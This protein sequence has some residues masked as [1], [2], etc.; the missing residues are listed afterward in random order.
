MSFSLSLSLHSYAVYFQARTGF[1]AVFL[2]KCTCHFFCHFLHK[3]KFVIPFD[4]IFSVIIKQETVL[5][6]TPYSVI[7]KFFLILVCSLFQTSHSS[8]WVL[9][10]GLL[11]PNKVC[12][13]VL[14]TLVYYCLQDYENYLSV[15]GYATAF[16]EFCV[17]ALKLSSAVAGWPLKFALK[18]FQSL[19][20]NKS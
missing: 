12:R 2:R 20:L 18:L 11:V 13:C 6:K 9:I 7:Y 1:Y 3:I 19:S 17:W 4:D 16:I 14:H 8:A 10:R 5:S 15:P